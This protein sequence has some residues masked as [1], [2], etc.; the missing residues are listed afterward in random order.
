[1]N[2]REP[3]RPTILDSAV[4]L[5]RHNHH[6]RLEDAGDV[7]GDQDEDRD[8]G[9]DWQEPG[10]RSERALRSLGVDDAGVVQEAV[11]QADDGRLLGEEVPPVLEG[12]VRGD[13]QRAAPVCC[14]HDTPY[15]E[16]GSIEFSKFLVTEAEVAVSP[17]VGFGPGGEGYVRVVT[18]LIWIRREE[19]GTV[20]SILESLRLRRK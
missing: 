13:A 8:Q 3:Q 18:Y 17:G 9:Q 5:T 6:R 7:G 10:S 1:M 2:Y 14:R 20:T 11:E 4:I 16:M 12:P 19:R 15:R